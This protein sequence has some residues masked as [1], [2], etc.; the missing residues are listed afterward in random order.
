MTIRHLRVFIAVVDAGSMTAAAKKLFIAQPSVSQTISELESYYKIRLFERLSK[1]L[2]ITEEGKRFLSYARHIVSSFDE[3]EHKMRQA[4]GNSVLKIG[5]SITVG[6][7]VLSKLYELFLARY[8][9]VD[10]E[11]VVDNTT[12]IEEM[13]LKSQLDFGLVEG[14]I[15]SKDIISK[16][17]M[18]DELILICGSK[19]PFRAKGHVT[20]QEVAEA[21]LILR[22]RGSGTRELFENTMSAKGMNL[23]IKWVCNNSEAIKNAVISNMGV[24][25]ISKMAV[26]YELKNNKLFHIIIDNI[27]LT[28]KFNIIYHK[29]KYISKVIEDFWNLCL[30]L[31]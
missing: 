7:C 29:N 1:K 13:V 30:T 10:I 18:D 27:K 3:M 6:T 4:A 26:D 8:P 14:P 19:H 11:S 15:H 23:N 24:S 2:Y 22:E 17:F 21:D 20:I 5:A 9:K 25:V 31:I 28:R 16:P 12:V